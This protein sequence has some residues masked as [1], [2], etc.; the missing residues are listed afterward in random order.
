M[1]EI[2]LTHG[3][4]TIVDD[5][6]FEWLSQWKWY[7]QLNQ[8]DGKYRAVRNKRIGPRNED[9]KIMIWM[10]RE[11]LGAGNEIKVDHKNH[12]PLDNRKINLRLATSS[13]N[14]MNAAIRKD[15]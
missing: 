5:E 11:I 15:S 14:N 7:A 1:K 12:N 8:S 9:R 2:Q 3:Q 6:D 4:V 10:H 13:Q